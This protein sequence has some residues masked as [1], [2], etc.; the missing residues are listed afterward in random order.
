MQQFSLRFDAVLWL[1]LKISMCMCIVQIREE[2]NCRN[3]ISQF[4][5][6]YYLYLAFRS[7]ILEFIFR[8]NLFIQYIIFHSFFFPIKKELAYFFL[9]HLKNESETEN[10]Q[11][12]MDLYSVTN[13]RFTPVNISA[14]FIRLDFVR[15]K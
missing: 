12:S 4:Q 13:N 10:T 2:R 6:H 3:K 15:K 7:I 9:C 14:N 5:N 11:H 8:S 1:Q